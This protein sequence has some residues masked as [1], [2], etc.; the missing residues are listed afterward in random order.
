MGHTSKDRAQRSRHDFNESIALHKGGMIATFNRLFKLV[1]GWS[2]V[3][4]GVVGLLV[5]VLPGTL[6]ILLGF[7]LLSSQSEIGSRL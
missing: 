3:S 2:L 6:F 1:F 4:R 5:P 7:E